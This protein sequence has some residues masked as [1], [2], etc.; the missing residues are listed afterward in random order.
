MNLDEIFDTADAI[1]PA[2]T[3]IPQSPS[4][5]ARKAHVSTPAAH[6]ALRWMAAHHYAVA[7]GNGAWTKYRTRRFG[8]I[9][10]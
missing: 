3:D 5:L 1:A 2:L 10:R 4:V 6:R 8:E 7:V 9:V